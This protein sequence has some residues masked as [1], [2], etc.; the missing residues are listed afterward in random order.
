ML[1]EDCLLTNQPCELT[2]TA[3]GEVKVL[4]LHGARQWLADYRA[5]K[6]E[7]TSSSW[8]LLEDYRA[9]KSTKFLAARPGK[10][11]E[12]VAGRE[13]ND[14]STAPLPPEWEQRVDRASGRTYFLNQN[15]RTTCWATVEPGDTYQL[16][17]VTRPL[18]GNTVLP[19]KQVYVADPQGNRFVTVMPANVA[20]G[21]MFEVR[22]PIMTPRRTHRARG[23][24]ATPPAGPSL[25]VIEEFV[26]MCRLGGAE[27]GGGIVG[28]GAGASSPA[29]GAG[30]GA[31]AGSDVALD[32]LTA[33][34]RQRRVA[35]VPD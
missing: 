18:H 25:G 2:V 3:V 13:V 32:P 21:A 6:S 29:G 24:H 10:G 19:G 4:V 17:Q 28:A 1:K 11:P 9:W 16:L 33:Q 12:E 8:R 22:V 27:G 14:P 20:P 23:A 26:P 15:E 30:G 5:W 34:L 7:E 35:R 31:T